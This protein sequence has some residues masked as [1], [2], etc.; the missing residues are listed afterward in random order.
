MPNAFK[1]TA[2]KYNVDPV[3]IRQLKKKISSLN[4]ERGDPKLTLISRNSRAKKTFH[5]RKPCFKAEHYNTLH[6][7]YDALQFS[8]HFVSV[9]MLSIELNQISGSL[10]PIH[11]LVQHIGCWHTSVGIVQPHI[12]HVAQ[13]TEYCE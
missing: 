2:W 8:S 11:V 3:Q 4:L 9:T 12:T 13:N 7:I 1:S 6:S 5:N 10:V